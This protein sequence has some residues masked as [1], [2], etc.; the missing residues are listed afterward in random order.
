[1]DKHGITI[2]YHLHQCT[3]CTPRDISCLKI[4]SEYDQDI[5]QSLIEIV[6]L[7]DDIGY[8]RNAHL[9]GKGNIN[10]H[11]VYSQCHH[12]KKNKLKQSYA[13]KIFLKPS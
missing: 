3:P 5:P 2:L 12:A 1:M 11:N 4:V 6:I 7:L 9:Y 8:I 10:E 13:S